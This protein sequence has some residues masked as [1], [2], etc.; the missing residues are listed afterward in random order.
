MELFIDKT[1]LQEVTAS[2]ASVCIC[3]FHKYVKIL[4]SFLFLASPKQ[5][6]YIILTS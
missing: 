6:I 4:I 3:E 1:R 2:L 5:L